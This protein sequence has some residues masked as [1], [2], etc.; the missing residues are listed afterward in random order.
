MHRSV[1]VR[2]VLTSCA[3]LFLCMPVLP[4]KHTVAL[5]VPNQFLIGRHTFFDFGPPTDFYELFVVRPAASGSS[6]ERITLIPPGNV[7]IAPAKVG[8]VSGS[9]NETTAE[10]LGSAN[11]CMIPEKE[12][13]RELKRC[14]N[15]L[16]F[17]GAEVVMQVRCGAQ[18]RLI[19][20]H[21][22][23]RDMFDATTKTPQHTSWTMRLLQRMDSA[24]GPGVIDT[25]RLFP[26]PEANEPSASSSDSGILGE[27]SA[28]KY[29]ALFQGAPD[30]LSDLYRASQI[31]L[32]PPKVQLVS[33][34][35]LQPDV[36]IE[37]VYPPIARMAHIEGRLAFKFVID[38]DGGATNLAFESG[39]PLL[40]GVVTEAVNRWRFPKDSTGQQIEATIEFRLNCPSQ[41]R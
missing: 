12:L 16:V 35:P 19:R 15:C 41:P 23:D 13:R 40:R 32:L 30:K 3:S 17:S 2:T 5:P 39:H 38:S 7:C 31:P 18:T 29:D 34:M 24:V 25:Q 27:V 10:L 11:P 37:P 21:I 22:L 28:G 14:K 33:S 1:I 9:I 4:Q 36:F 8:A 20:S 26:V 6:I